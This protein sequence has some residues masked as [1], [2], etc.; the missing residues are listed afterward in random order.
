MW[1]ACDGSS[2][3]GQ[4]AVSVTAKLGEPATEDLVAF[5]I[6]DLAAEGLLTTPDPTPN[7]SGLSRREALRKI[8]LGTAVVIPIVVGIA[9]PAA[10]VTNSACIPDDGFRECVRDSCTDPDNDRYSYCKDSAC[11]SGTCRR[12]PDAKPS[13]V[14]AI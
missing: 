4:I 8:G 5:C 1:A 6:D 2:D 3:V 14:P 7:F 12:H 13:C 9:S 11:C 10:A